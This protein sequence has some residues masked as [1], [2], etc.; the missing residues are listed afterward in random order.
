MASTTRGA[1]FKT[2]GGTDLLKGVLEL[3]A[4]LNVLFRRVEPA[5][6]PVRAPT[7]ARRLLFVSLPNPGADLLG[8]TPADESG[9]PVWPKWVRRPAEGEPPYR[10]LELADPKALASFAWLPKSVGSPTIT[11]YAEL[12]MR[13]VV[14]QGAPPVEVAAGSEI[15]VTVVVELADNAKELIARLTA[16]AQFGGGEAVLLRPQTSEPGRLNYS[17]TVPVPDG[18]DRPVLQ[19]RLRVDDP[20]AGKWEWTRNVTL[21]ATGEGISP[22]TIDP[23]ETDLGPQWDDQPVEPDPIVLRSDTPVTVTAEPPE[24]V[25]ALPAEINVAPGAESTMQLALSPTAPLGPFEAPMTL[26]IRNEDGTDLARRSVLLKGAVFHW[27]A[28]EVVELGE[29]KAGELRE[30]AV[31]APCTPYGGDG[32]ATAALAHTA[33]EAVILPLTAAF[34]ETG[35]LRLALTVP[36]DATPGEYTGAVECRFGDELAPRTIPV[37]FVVLGVEEVPPK[38]TALT[39]SPDA[40]TA[41]GDAGATVEAELAVEGVSAEQ[42]PADV[43]LTNLVAEKG[44]DVISARFDCSYELVYPENAPARLVLRVAVPG[45]VSPGRY[46]GQMRIWQTAESEPKVVELEIDVP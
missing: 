17:A 29:G 10:V 30:T 2:R 44:D 6:G 33:D 18:L 31:N 24:A 8:A 35:E 36:D 4:D 23:P 34:E 28:P 3:G 22:L 16:E 11:P 21:R 19:I 7:N 12:P 20:D 40:V 32:V 26:R 43:Q 42:P 38:R 5:T 45:D 39:I 25:V 27:E 9:A 46:R 15:P 13:V 14:S 1:R 41:S 37:K